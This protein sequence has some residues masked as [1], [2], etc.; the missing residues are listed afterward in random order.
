MKRRKKRR[1]CAR[2]SGMSG[3]AHLLLA[4]EV[5]TPYD[6]Q[7]CV[8]VSSDEVAP[9]GL[10]PGVHRHL[11]RSDR[12]GAKNLQPLHTWGGLCMSAVN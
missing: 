1:F 8:R 6:W 4:L 10:R 11:L 2:V 9:G 7:Y 12:V 3:A 5:K